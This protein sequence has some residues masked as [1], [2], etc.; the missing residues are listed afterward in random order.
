MVQ[1]CKMRCGDRSALEDSSEGSSSLESTSVTS[2]LEAD[3]QAE[4]TA[5]SHDPRHLP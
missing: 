4:E 1:E 2:S 5:Y 3:L